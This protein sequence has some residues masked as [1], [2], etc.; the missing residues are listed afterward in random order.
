M[1]LNYFLSACRPENVH[2]IPQMLDILVMYKI[3]AEIF[4]QG[5]KACHCGL[6]A[7]STAVWKSNSILLPNAVK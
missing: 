2:L 6:L 4:P 7:F 1:Y 3:I 5:L